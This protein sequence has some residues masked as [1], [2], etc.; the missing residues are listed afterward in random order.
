M[1]VFVLVG[2][3]VSL[4]ACGAGVPATSPAQPTPAPQ[5]TA[6]VAPTA[7]PPTQIISATD[8][9]PT[10]IPDT[11]VP[12]TTAPTAA[13]VPATAPAA[14]PTTFTLQEFSVPPRT[15]PHDV[16]PAADGGIWY[17]GQNVGAL[18]YLDVNTGATRHIPLGPNSAPHGV[19]LGPDNAPWITDGGQNAIVRVDPATDKVDV[20]PLPAGQPNAN[21]NTAVFDQNGVL[22]FTGQRG[23]YGK[24]DPKVGVV[25]AW[26][27]PR[28][29]GPYGIT[30]TPNGDIYYAS[31][32]GNHIARINTQT[33][34]AVV[35]E[36]PTAGQGARRVW[37]DSHGNIWVSEWNAGQVGKYDPAANAWQEWKLPGAR[38]QAYAVYV[39]EN[40]KVWLTDFGGNAL[41]RFDPET[42]TFK[43]YPF[44]TPG[45]TV[46]QLLG[47]PGEI[48]GAESGLDRIVVARAALE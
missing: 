4:S 20:Y 30:V 8:T 16:A 11:V 40:D 3:L 23:V 14:E 38:P 34:E 6:I 35:I 28:G 46:R 41:V 29:R 31:L 18:G 21:L 5:P 19:I 45:A 26:D 27:A 12:N 37:S 36:P 1:R 39:D 13:A 33:N 44:D 7:L 47:R 2:L 32:A 48:W 22:W 25:E 43:E 42:E 15:H 17:T 24:L 10:T 9:A